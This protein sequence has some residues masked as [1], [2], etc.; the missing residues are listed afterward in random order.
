MQRALKAPIMLMGLSLPGD[1]Y[2]AP[3]ESYGWAQAAGGIK[4][5]VNYFTQVSKL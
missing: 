2:H 4:L 5:F 1:G 3:D